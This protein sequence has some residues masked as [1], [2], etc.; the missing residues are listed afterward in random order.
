MLN[1]IEKR[2]K[3]RYTNLVLAQMNAYDIMLPD[4]SI[5]IVVENA[6]LHLVDNPESVLK[7]IVRVLKPSGR[8]IRYRSPGMLLQQRK[9]RRM[10]IATPSFPI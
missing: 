3:G 10:Y 1:T 7:E 2:A 6:M 4:N 5:D 8:L 9:P